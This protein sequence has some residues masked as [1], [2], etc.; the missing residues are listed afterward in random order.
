MVWKR[1]VCV[2]TQENALG[3][4]ERNGFVVDEGWEVGLKVGLDIWACLED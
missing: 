2:H 3:A 4:W 1:L